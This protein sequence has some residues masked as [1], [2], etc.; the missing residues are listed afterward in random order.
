[1]THSTAL[2]TGYYHKRSVPFLLSLPGLRR[3]L[4]DGFENASI[5]E[6]DEDNR[7]ELDRLP[8]LFPENLH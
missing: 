2:D 6:T 5:E 1:M 4:R 8:K 7:K 3:N